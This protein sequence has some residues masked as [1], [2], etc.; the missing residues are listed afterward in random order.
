MMG[1]LTIRFNLD[2]ENAMVDALNVRKNQVIS[3]LVPEWQAGITVTANDSIAAYAGDAVRGQAISVQATFEQL[4]DL[5]SSAEIRAVA[6]MADGSSL[7][8]LP[9]AVLGSLESQTV[10]FAANGLSGP[11]PF[12][13]LS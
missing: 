11:I 12:T 3:A 6:A 2:D 8:S 13:A 4:G 1:I 7:L 10:S 5:V 9:M